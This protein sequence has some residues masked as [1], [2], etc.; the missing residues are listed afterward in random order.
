MEYSPRELWQGSARPALALLHP[1]SP[2]FALAS[3][4]HLRRLAIVA[5]ERARPQTWG[6]LVSSSSTFWFP[7]FF[8]ALLLHFPCTHCCRCVKS[9]HWEG[10]AMG[11]VGDR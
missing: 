1:P 4:E 8:F 10:S 11:L 3:R 7:Y 2:S 6:K 5:P 9:P